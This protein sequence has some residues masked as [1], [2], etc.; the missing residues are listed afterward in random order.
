MA[1]VFTGE[2]AI[3][4]VF[5]GPAVTLPALIGPVIDEVQ[6]YVVPP[7][8]EVGVKLSAVALQIVV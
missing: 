1:P 2:S 7:T 3:G 5:T 4:M 6:L 8:L